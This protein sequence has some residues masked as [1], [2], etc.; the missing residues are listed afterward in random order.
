M[1]TSSIRRLVDATPFR[2]FEIRIADGRSIPVHHREFIMIS[3]ADVD[4]VVYQPDGGID[5]VATNLVT[6][7]QLKAPKRRSSGNK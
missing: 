2:P 6:G 7:L 4:F 1:S 5:I 3:P